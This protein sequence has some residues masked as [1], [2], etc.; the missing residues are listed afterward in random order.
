MTGRFALFWQRN[1]GRR[2]NTKQLNQNCHTAFSFDI[3]AITS[4]SWKSVANAAQEVNQR[5]S[6]VPLAGA[7]SSNPSIRQLLTEEFALAF[8]CLL[9]WPQLGAKSYLQCTN[10]HNTQSEM[11]RAERCVPATFNTH[12]QSVRFFL[13]KHASGHFA[14]GTEFYFFSP[15]NRSPA[16]NLSG[17]VW[18]H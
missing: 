1:S 13:A 3:F 10:E 14:S 12:F 7:V 15:H 8:Y 4:N 18:K 9:H 17:I 6:V 5:R 2:I 11:C 16:I